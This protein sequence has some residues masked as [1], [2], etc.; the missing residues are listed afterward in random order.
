[1]SIEQAESI[2][3]QI[4]LIKKSKSTTWQWEGLS[5][6]DG[7][8]AWI[9]ARFNVDKTTVQRWFKQATANAFSIDYRGNDWHVIKFDL[10]PVEVPRLRDLQWLK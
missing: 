2:L 6:I 10:I 5:I 1:M 4:D 3:F 8:E 9:D 7:Q